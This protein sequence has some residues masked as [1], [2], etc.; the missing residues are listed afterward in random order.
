MTY[1]RKANERSDDRLKRQVT[2]GLWALAGIA[3]LALLFIGASVH[4]PPT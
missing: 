1:E 2:Q 3:L 4:N